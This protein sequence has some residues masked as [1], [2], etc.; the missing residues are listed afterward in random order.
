MTRL[1]IRDFAGMGGF[2]L[3]PGHVFLAFFFDLLKDKR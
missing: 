2:L 3:Q 1:V